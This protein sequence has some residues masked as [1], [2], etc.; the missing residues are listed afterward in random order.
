LTVRLPDRCAHEPTSRSAA[1][2][3]ADAH[4]CR[5]ARRCAAL[6]LSPAEWCTSR[7]GGRVV[8]DVV[9]FTG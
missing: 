6:E 4:S 2:F 1:E 5:V 9:A 3:F 8:A 7:A